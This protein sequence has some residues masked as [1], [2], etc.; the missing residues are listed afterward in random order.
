MRRADFVEKS[1]Q[2][3]LEGAKSIIS[4]LLTFIYPPVSSIC[5]HITRASSNTVIASGIASSFIFAS[6]FINVGT[7]ESAYLREWEMK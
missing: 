4:L 5:C 6:V 3:I 7:M 2:T 1:K